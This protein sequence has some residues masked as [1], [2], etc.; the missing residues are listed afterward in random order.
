MHTQ[1]YDSG[2]KIHYNGGFDG[3]VVIIDTSSGQDNWEKFPEVKVPTGDLIDFVAMLIRYKGE[4]WLEEVE[5]E[6]LL[7]MWFNR[8]EKVR[9]RDGKKYGGS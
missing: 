9:K 5:D 8:V 3:D 4:E 1:T 6:D 2:I 7:R